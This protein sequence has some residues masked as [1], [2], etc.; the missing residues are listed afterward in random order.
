MPEPKKIGKKNNGKLTDFSSFEDVQFRN[1]P[2]KFIRD[3]NSALHFFKKIDFD[4]K[5]DV[6]QDVCNYEL[7]PDLEDLAD[8]NKK[9]SEEFVDKLMGELKVERDR[10]G[11]D[12]D[13]I[14][15][16]FEESEEWSITRRG[17]GLTIS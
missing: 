14:M 9:K 10:F 11:E 4:L 12:F 13:D 16:E 2:N 5:F 15:L 3:Y 17:T 6:A 7:N 1:V 8:F